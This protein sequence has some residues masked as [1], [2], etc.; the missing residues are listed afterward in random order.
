MMPKT[1]RTTIH[2]Y[3]FDLREEDEKKK[4]EQ[5]KE[6]LKGQG[7]KKLEA[8]G[9]FY[10][11]ILPIDGREIE[12]ETKH[13]FNNQWNTAPIKGVSE[14]GL[15]VFD[16]AR[17]A[18]STDWN[19]MNSNLASPP[20]IAK[21]HYLEQTD[22]MKAIRHNTVACGYCGWQE[23]ASTGNTF[24]P[25]CLGN[26][27]LEQNRLFL[28]RMK[29]IDDS[30]ER[31]PLT[32]AEEDHLVPLYVKAQTKAGHSHNNTYVKEKRKKIE[33][34]YKRAMQIAQEEHDGFIWLLDKDINIE[35]CIYYSHRGIFSFGWRG[36]KRL[37]KEV[38]D[39]LKKQLEH[40]PFDYEIK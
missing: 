7:I 11:H 21:G 40:F 4:W 12:L 25:E 39:E 35:N 22:E 24:C 14:K 20:Y 27:Y 28:L 6:K 3:C 26:E 19:R 30:T 36:G 31:E 23:P 29:R 13:L 8:F 33:D 10:R 1:I 37:S 34:K 17:D 5:L 2:A 15:R 16:W 18:T 32:K 9:K 38:K